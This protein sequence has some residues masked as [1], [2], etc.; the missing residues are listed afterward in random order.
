MRND[1]DLI[2]NRLV[3][4]AVEAL[5]ALDARL[6]DREQTML[7]WQQHDLEMAFKRIQ[8]KTEKAA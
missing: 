5:N 1:Y 2:T 7:P 3:Y 4:A 6:I 8:Y